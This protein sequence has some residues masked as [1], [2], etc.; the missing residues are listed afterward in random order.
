MDAQFFEKRL[1]LCGLRRGKRMFEGN[2]VSCYAWSG[3][4]AIFREA[5]LTGVRAINDVSRPTWLK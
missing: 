2:C 1:L 3:A 4:G 5:Q